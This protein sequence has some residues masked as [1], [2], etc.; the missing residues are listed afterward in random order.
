MAHHDASSRVHQRTSNFN[1]FCD[2][3]SHR[4]ELLAVARDH[5]IAYEIGW[6]ARTDRLTFATAE[7]CV[8]HALAH[9]IFATSL[10]IHVGHEA[11]MQAAFDGV[12]I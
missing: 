11:Y 9:D 4:E 1:L 7:E 5:W 3:M 12:A 10:I 2:Y 8:A 6:L